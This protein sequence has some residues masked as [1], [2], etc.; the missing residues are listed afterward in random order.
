MSGAKLQMLDRYRIDRADGAAALG[1]EKLIVL[2][3]KG[4]GEHEQYF[5]ISKMDAMIISQQLH[6]A[7]HE[8]QSDDIK[9]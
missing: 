3:L 6:A 2:M 9:L 4:N 5:V 1:P 7:A 8:A